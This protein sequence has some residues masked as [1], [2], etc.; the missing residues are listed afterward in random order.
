M[1]SGELERV[2]SSALPLNLYSKTWVVLLRRE[3]IQFLVRSLYPDAFFHQP[4]NDPYFMLSMLH[5]KSQQERVLLDSH[6]VDSTVF[7]WVGSCEIAESTALLCDFT[8]SIATAFSKKKEK[9]KKELSKKGAKSY[10]GQ[11]E[12]SS[13]WV[14]ALVQHE[15]AFQ[16]TVKETVADDYST[17]KKNKIKRIWLGSIQP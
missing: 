7:L 15:E 2:F 12:F 14:N 10:S 4:Q 5:A 16:R 8:S 17:T 9:K 3:Q 13:V 1:E 11:S 6:S